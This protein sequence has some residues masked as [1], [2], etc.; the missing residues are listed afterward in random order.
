MKQKAIK[1]LLSVV[2]VL[3][4][5]GVTTMAKPKE[6]AACYPAYM[7]IK[8]A[9]KD[10]LLVY[11]NPDRR[12][13]LIIGGIVLGGVGFLGN[14]AGVAS[15]AVGVYSSVKETYKGSMSFKTYIKKSDKK[16][17]KFRSKTVYY[18]KT[19]YKGKKTTKYRYHN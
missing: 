11:Q 1:M 17:Y 10:W 14:T 16:G 4:M 2:L 9:P 5:F 13:G 18:S 6:A 7:C 15:F 19:K 8:T 3:S 12:K